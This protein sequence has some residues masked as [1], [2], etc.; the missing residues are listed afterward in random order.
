[1]KRVGFY[2]LSMVILMTVI[3]CGCAKKDDVYELSFFE[4]LKTFTMITDTEVNETEETWKN[5]SYTYIVFEDAEELVNEYK[6][7]LVEDYGFSISPDADAGELVFTLNEQ[8]I[9]LTINEDSIETKV[10]ITV[11]FNT[12][13]ANTKKDE[14]Y[15]KVLSLCNE[16]KYEEAKE[17]FYKDATGEYKDILK[18]VNYCEAQILISSDNF[19]YSEAIKELEGASGFKDADD[20]KKELEKEMKS[21]NG[22]YYYK[23][24]G[25]YLYSHYYVVIND[26]EVSLDLL[27]DKIDMNKKIYYSWDLKKLIKSDDDK[28]EVGIGNKYGNNSLFATL[29][30][31]NDGK[32]QFYCDD[33]NYYVYEGTYNK[34]SS[35]APDKR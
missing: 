24:G 35:S 15:Q 16:G 17:F 4:N 27:K 21:F 29:S 25:G 31:R 30:K 13:T 2:L 10:T 19:F 22:V 23:K 26:G 12:D 8:E 33:S 5:K 11:P 3:C 1:M 34:I 32:I 6:R 9:S 20:I 7:Y 18:I 14:I 28:W